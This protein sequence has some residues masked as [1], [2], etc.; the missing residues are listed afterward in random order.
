M[1]ASNPSASDKELLEDFVLKRHEESFDTLVQRYKAALFNVAYRVLYDRQA[2][3]DVVQRVFLRLFERREELIEVESLRSWLYT[4]ALHLSFDMKKTRR[5]RRDREKAGAATPTEDT[6]REAAVKAELGKELDGALAKLKDPFRIPLVLRYLQGLSHAETGKILNA[7]PDAIRMRISRG[8]KR[9]RKLLKRRGLLVTVLAL[10]EGL[11]SLP[12]EAVSAGFLTSASSIIKAASAG[13]LA[14]KATATTALVVKGGLMMT[15]KTKVAIGVAAAVLAGGMITYLA[16]KSGDKRGVAQPMKS[17][18]APPLGWLRPKANSDGGSIP[19]DGPREE[20]GLFGYVVDTEGNAVIGASVEAGVFEGESPDSLKKKVSVQ[21]TTT[22]SNGEFRFAHDA[23]SQ[24]KELLAPKEDASDE[25]PKQLQTVVAA[26]KEGYVLAREPIDFELVSGPL[27]L[28]LR[29]GA[30]V[31]GQVIWKERHEPIARVRILCRALNWDVYR[32]TYGEGLTDSEGNFKLTAPFEGTVSVYPWLASYGSSYFSYGRSDLPGEL[33]LEL[34]AADSVAGL[35]LEVGLMSDTIIEGRVV[36][37]EG[38]P[39]AGA[40]MQLSTDKAMS[41]STTSEEDGWYR[42]MVA[43]DWAYQSYY[44]KDWADKPKTSGGCSSTTA[45]YISF[46]FPEEESKRDLGKNEWDWAIYW[47]PPPNAPPERIVG[48]HPDYELGF[49]EVHQLG[50]GQ[51]WRGVDI[52]LHKGSKVSGR[53][54]DDALNPIEEAGIAIEVKPEESPALVKLDQLLMGIGGYRYAREPADQG[55]LTQK[56]GSF[57]IRFLREG[58]YD[59]TAYKEGYDRLTKP[60]VLG[61]H[62]VVERFDFIL[63][64]HKDFIRGKVLDGGGSP[65]PYGTV[66]TE[67]GQDWGLGYKA[68]VREDGTYELIGMRTGKFDLW[69]D[70]SKDYPE[71]EGIPW[72]T[73]LKQVPSGTEGAD[74]IVSHY[75]AGGLRVRVIDEA[76]RP[77]QKFH[78]LCCPLS[79][80]HGKSGVATGPMTNY[81]GSYSSYTAYNRDR[82]YS[83]ILHCKRDVVSEAG[84]FLAQR[85]APG[86]YFVSVKSDEHAEKFAEVVIE[87]GKQAELRFGLEALGRIEGVIVDRDGNPLE[88]LCLQA[89]KMNGFLRPS[90]RRNISEQFWAISKYWLRHKSGPDGRFTFEKLER[91]EYRVFAKADSGQSVF[92][93]VTIGRDGM[94]F[95]RLVF[96][97]GTGAIEGFVR[98]EGGMIVT[99]ATVVLEGDGQKFLARVDEEGRYA[100]QN[101]PAGKYIVKAWMDRSWIE[102]RAQ[103][104]ALR[105][106]E[107]TTV[108]IIAAGDG[109]I[110]GTVSLVGDAARAETWCSV[111]LKEQGYG[112]RLVLRS[113]MESGIASREIC[114]PVGETFEL[115]NIPAGTYEVHARLE[116]RINPEPTAFLAESSFFDRGCTAIFVSEPQTVR[117]APGSKAPINL[118]I[119][120]PL[121]PYYPIPDPE[122]CETRVPVAADDERWEDE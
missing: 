60:L 75:P 24:A 45:G 46:V 70:V 91:T 27:M 14:A 86:S 63:P 43:R 74:I 88:G 71:P 81:K 30:E 7:S 39:V 110:E 55:T 65:W 76:Y 34:T 89:I 13:G 3:E 112:R 12:A 79:L 97:T 114:L 48:F 59:L 26:S 51:I 8:L 118:T 50:I 53:V 42:L 6:P 95:V 122:K 35:V 28:I 25:A 58:S 2:A 10:E 40:Q 113:V 103:E 47:T 29:K 84:E 22:D 106:G 31:S 16:T 83:G 109:A 121:V 52:V 92:K 44:V 94:A 20:A 117:V 15:A 85:A 111:R 99:E 49:A 72:A 62:G 66:K 73:S 17:G 56:D 82:K 36:D 18:G 11:R 93:D 96:E 100:L 19:D 102:Y 105:Q 32:S 77:I 90:E 4:T 104:V 98:G 78:I 87:E 23:F 108:D 57:D 115:N 68:D 107:R 38:N 67:L 101:V 1:E 116:E 64:R 33:T 119:S 5:R 21:S 54:L 9:L 69:L 61:P 120:Q 80:V 41:P 37:A